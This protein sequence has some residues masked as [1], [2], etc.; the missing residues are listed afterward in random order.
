PAAAKAHRQPALAGQPLQGLAHRRA[1]GLHARR[2]LA[3]AEAVTGQQAEL[4]DVLLELPV[5]A[6][7]EAVVAPVGVQRHLEHQATAGSSSRS[8]SPGSTALPG[9][10]RTVRTVPLTGAVTASSI[11]MA[12]TISSGAPSS[13]A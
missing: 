3:L 8:R 10:Q 4:E 12:S 13:T 6:L 1:A 11:F 2:Q 9:W 7:G 5:D